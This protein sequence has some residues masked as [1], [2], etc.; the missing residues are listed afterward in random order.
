MNIRLK[1][2]KNYIIVFILSVILS[3]L[4]YVYGMDIS[5]PSDSVGAL[6]S[7]PFL[8]G[9]NWGNVVSRCSYYG[10]GY[11]WIFFLLFK[12]TD[13]YRLIYFIIFLT[14]FLLCCL[15]SVIAYYIMIEFLHLKKSAMVVFMAAIIPTFRHNVHSI[16]NEHAIFV[17]SWLAALV[18]FKLIDIRE[19][20]KSKNMYTIILSI[21]MMYS[22]SIHERMFA[23]WL[24]L[25][26]TVIIVRLLCNISFVS[27]WIITLILGCGYVLHRIVRNVVAQNLWQVEDGEYIK[28]MSVVSSLNQSFCAS[29]GNIKA[30]LDCMITNIYK[31][32]ISSYGMIIPGIILVIICFGAFFRTKGERFKEYRTEENLKSFIV[33]LIFGITM[34]VVMAGL[35]T[36]GAASIWEGYS[37]GE[38]T[39]GYKHFFYVRYYWP[40][41]GPCM[42]ASFAFLIK[43]V[44]RLKKL[45]AICLVAFCSCFAYMWIS[46]FPH[47]RSSNY[48]SGRL[49]YAPII[50]IINNT[51]TKAGEN[52]NLLFTFSIMILCIVLLC[53][54]EKRHVKILY[55]SIITLLLSINTVSSLQGVETR[56][57]T[58]NAADKTF[59]FFETIENEGI[60]NE[61][62][63]IYEHYWNSP[64]YTYQFVLNRYVFHVFSEEELAN[65]PVE[66]ICVSNKDYTTSAALEDC[67][68]I[69]LDGAEYVYVKG[70]KLILTISDFYPLKPCQYEK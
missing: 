27:E 33:T 43:H 51:K 28:N 46:I 17:V 53:F 26:L 36:K 62:Y 64:L 49:N 47:L 2:N 31:L 16:E 29:W 66:A 58:C 1:E 42:I 48:L 3:G 22:L 56:G 59:E 34:L 30:T 39:W 68:Y 45:F 5:V 50:S 54:I 10:Y 6:A 4:K 35:A 12:L 52:I 24:G 65:L 25:V 11:H 23:L 14:G 19:N 32:A 69:E 7:A 21:I 9:L 20:Q 67:Y 18:L 15:V 13:N 37:T 41:I 63:F 61:I 40:F 44:N 55:C 60:P 38:I 57:I 8:A 70:E